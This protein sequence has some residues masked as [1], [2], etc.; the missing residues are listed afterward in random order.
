MTRDGRLLFRDRSH[1]NLNGSRFLAERLLVDY[2]EL[3]AAV[4]RAPIR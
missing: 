3:V 4:T 1:L 2:P